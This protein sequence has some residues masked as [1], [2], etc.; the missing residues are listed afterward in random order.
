[1]KSLKAIIE[2]GSDGFYSV[3]VPE[4]PGLYGAGETESDAKENLKEAIEVAIDHMEETGDTTYYA[5]L[6]EDHTIEYAYDLS[7]F[8]KTIDI[9]DV[10]ALSKRIGINSSLMRRYKTGMSKASASQKAKILD[11][12]YSVADDLLAVKF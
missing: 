3:Y 4:I 12:I 9:F 8:F 1:M 11:G 7:G 2:K 10:T 6:M 5:P